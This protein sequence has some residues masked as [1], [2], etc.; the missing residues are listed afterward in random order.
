MSNWKLL[1]GVA[2]ASIMTAAIVAPAEAQVTTSGVRGSITTPDGSPVSGANI[3]LT[4]TRTGFTRQLVSS[5]TGN[6]SARGMNVGGPYRVEVSADGQPT[7]AVEGIFVDLGDVTDLNLQ[8]PAADTDRMMD[9]VVVTASAGSIVQTAIGPSSSFTLEDL[10][11]SPAINRDLK[12]IVRIDPRVFLDVANEDGIQC[13][14]AS[15]RF[16]SLTVDGVGLND[17]FGLNDNGY[18]TQ[19]SSFPFDAIQNVSVELAPF[20]VNYGTFTACNINAVTKS[21]T[22]EFHGSIFFDYTDD[23]LQGDTLS[24]Q[25]ISR[26]EFDEQRRGASI[27]GPIIKDKLFF[28]GAY[29]KFEGFDIFDRGPIGSGAG[30]EVPDFTQADFDRIRQIAMNVYDYD[31][32]GVPGA[33][34]TSDEKYLMRLDWNINDQHRATATYLYNESISLQESDGDDDEFEYFNHLYGRGAELK[35]YSA[36][37]YSDW[38]PNLSTEFR[39]SL[40]E[41]DFTQASIAGTDFG[42]VQVE[43]GGSTIYLGADDSRHSNDLN[44]NVETLRGVANYSWNDHLITFGGERIAYDI[45]N[46]FAQHTQGQWEFDSIDDFENGNLETFFYGNAASGN[47]ADT[48]QEFTYEI[49]TLFVQDEFELDNGVQI[50]AGLRYDFY[51]S[52]DAPRLNENFVAR[53]GFANTGTFDGESLLQPRFGV[54]WDY[55]DNLSLRGG[56]GL[57]SGGNPNVWLSNSFSNDG[58]SNIQQNSFALPLPG[59]LLDGSVTFLNDEGGM[60]RPIYGIPSEY[61]DAVENGTANSTVNAIDPNIK[62]PANWKFSAGFTYDFDLPN[63]FGNGYVLNGDILH[64]EIQSS[65]AVRDISRVVDGTAPDGRPIYRPTFGSRTNDF[66]LTNGEEGY[67]TVISGSLAKSY[68]DLGKWADSFDWSIGYAYT[69][70]KNSASQVSAIAFSNYTGTATTDPNNLPVTT[71][72]YEIPHRWTMRMSWKKDFFEG[73]TTTATLFGQAYQGPAFSYT[74]GRDSSDVFGDVNDFRNLLYVPTGVD[75]PLVEFAPGFDT[76]AFFDYVDSRGL[77]RGA[78]TGRNDQ[79]GQW[80]NQFDLYLEQ[81]FPGVKADHRT[82]GFVTVENIGNLI[83]DDWGQVHEAS[84]FQTTSIVDLGDALNAN[85]QYVYERFRD[86]NPETRITDQSFWNLRFGVRYEF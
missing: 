30:R 8:F 15:P 80:T 56:F 86:R 82:I 14:G 62:I 20:D 50:T 5:A 60:G 77:E 83:N 76:A 1:S 68:D 18:P 66:L 46:L 79:D 9:T 22:N 71:S 16:N 3:V 4:D 6:F 24:G 40:N 58:F 10:Q 52:D 11:N 75:D 35:A 7:F 28:F 69:E 23:T 45:F 48:S 49:N 29:E 13:G 26:P 19:R 84:F 85:G 41:V 47:P 31:P 73:L 74:F 38:T 27:G 55:S 33:E 39:Y 81:E 25:K 65:F 42:E 17:G 70:A 64:T 44:Y 57:Y 34:P 72:N 59:N 12:D 37:V 43:V 36:A 78:I 21:G 53:N 67:E 2:A 61:V 32:G 63:G 51:T 54:S